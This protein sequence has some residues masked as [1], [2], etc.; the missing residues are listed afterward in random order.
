MSE[1]QKETTIPLHLKEKIF[2]AIEAQGGFAEDLL[3]PNSRYLR[4]GAIWN[5]NL[6][7]IA[8]NVPIVIRTIHDALYG[9]IP[10]KVDPI[11]QILYRNYATGTPWRGTSDVIIGWVQFD[12][13]EEVFQGLIWSL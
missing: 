2:E 3:T 4:D 13:V 8:P 12:D 1:P 5:T 10:Y 7:Q 9:V 6:I 11:N